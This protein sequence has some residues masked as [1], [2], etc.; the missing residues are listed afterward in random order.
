MTG[1]EPAAEA[2][3]ARF[4]ALPQR[5][6]FADLVEERPPTDRPAAGYDPDALAVRFA[7]LAA[8]LGL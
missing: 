6:A 4:G 3:R 7:C 5:I 1:R 8:D 2:R